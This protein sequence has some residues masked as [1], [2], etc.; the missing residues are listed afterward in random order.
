MAL[1]L[2]ERT[3]RDKRLE[4]IKKYEEEEKRQDFIKEEEI[5]RILEEKAHPEPAEV[6][7]VLAKARELKGLSPEDTAVLI[8]TKDPELLQ[9]LFETA[10]WIK[11]Q[12]YGNR[13]VL[14]APLYVSS[15]CVNNCV[16][17]GFRH[18][19]EAVYKR[20]LTMEELAQ[21]VRV[22]TRVGH[23]RVLAVFG[24]H[25]ASDVDYICRSLE[26]IYAT[27]HGRDEIRRV[28][29]NAAP[30]TVEEYRQIKEVGIGTYQV[31]QETYHHET[32]RRLH[33]PDTL[34]HSY[35][36]RLF[37]LH[38]AQEAGIDD[39]AIGV[40]FGLFDWRF[41]VLGLLYHAMDLEREFGVGPHTISF[42]RLEPAL[43]TP[44]TT[45]S[46][47]LVS[48]EELKK[49]I[50]ILRCAV[51]Y[52]GLILTARE[53]PELRRELIRLG[54][55]QTDAGS[56]IA[57]GGYSEM[58]KEHI[59]E[60]QQFKIN[61]TRSLDEFIYDL[62]QDGY[63]PSFCTAGY[64]AGRTGCH[65]MEF[66]KKGLVKNFCV[67]NAILTFKEYLLDYASPR[68]RELGEKVI[69]RYLQEVE[70]RLPRLAEK[71]REYL[72]RMEAGERDLYV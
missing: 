62:C 9:E 11:N 43:N 50:A 28:N 35:K 46:P 41:E 24:E 64:R 55:S 72:A 44:F 1:S 18:S 7:E 51:P 57:V 8:N 2:A 19:N 67:P 25:P 71:V 15:P 53:N 4:M 36:W 39:V 56:R 63:I 26:T 3:W 17:C 60:R 58:E 49:I 42:P 20:T 34:K 30:M 69:E 21:E 66:A 37:A 22:I 68:T 5:W 54:V 23:K 14:F 59:L 29:V 65:F 12:V 38:R 61:D 27:K 13:I 48:D 47:Y 52:T 70:E 33:P 40:L 31:F 10:F 32:Y 16:Y 6:R 45:N